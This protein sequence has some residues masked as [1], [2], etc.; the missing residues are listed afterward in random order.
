M[1]DIKKTLVRDWTAFL[2]GQFITF[3]LVG[4]KGIWSEF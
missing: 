3:I 4:A 1:N 2:L